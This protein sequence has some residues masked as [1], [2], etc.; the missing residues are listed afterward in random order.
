MNTKN[1]EL[2]K[3]AERIA[4]TAYDEGF[5][6]EREYRGCAQCAVSGMQNALNFRNDA[7]YKA[8]SGLA[9]GVGECT[10]GVCGGFSGA[11]MMMS[12]FFGRPRS[13]EATEKGRAMKY[14]SF[15]MAAAL[16]DKFIE[17]FGSV[18][19]SDIHKKLF[20]RS[21]NLRDD[22]Q[23][24]AFRDSGAHE[25]DDKCCAVVGIGAKWGVELI[26][27]ELEKEGLSLEDFS[28][29]KFTE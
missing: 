14:D 10:D 17:K 29:L 9:G 2:A 19:C 22:E 16:H 13:E 4:Q 11:V 23:K 26:L 6:G 27:E 25:L 21:F 1:A 8:A 24:Q 3:E 7:V 12:L 5:R 20:G 18:I 15:R 28:H